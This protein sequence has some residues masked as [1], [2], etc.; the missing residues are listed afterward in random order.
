MHAAQ[1][2][3]CGLREEAEGA[4]GNKDSDRGGI[5]GRMMLSFTYST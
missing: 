4:G 3:V 1:I 5:A 2:D